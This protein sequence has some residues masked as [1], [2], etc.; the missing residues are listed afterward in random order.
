SQMG[1]ALE[2]YR[3]IPRE[4]S[5][6]GEPSAL[7]VTMQT[8]PELP[9]VGVNSFEVKAFD[10][11]GAAI[12]DA[13]ISLILSMPAMPSMNMPAMHSTMALKA[14]GSGTYTGA[15]PISMAGRWDVTVIVRRHNQ[16]PGST[17]TTL[18]VR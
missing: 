1:A 7:R 16:P 9:R 10:P 13:D 11:S 5:S 12:A 3:A 8:E 18:I 17:K 15:G 4:N 6:D 14:N 2:G